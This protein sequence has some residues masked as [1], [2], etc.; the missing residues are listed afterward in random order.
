MNHEIGFVQPA[1]GQFV[2]I[3]PCIGRRKSIS[4]CTLQ[5][6]H[7][8]QES[9]LGSGESFSI[10]TLQEFPLKNLNLSY[11]NIRSGEKALAD[12]LCKNSTLTSL[13]LSWNKFG[14]KKEK[15]W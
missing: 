2:S 6:L 4:R 8:N 11:N 15:Y 9:E 10:C 14:Q 12:A 7:A 5:E 13:D 1:M 3:L